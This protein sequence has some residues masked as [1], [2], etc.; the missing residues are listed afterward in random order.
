MITAYFSLISDAISD[1]V[2]GT[3]VGSG[4]D[5]RSSATARSRRDARTEVTCNGPDPVVRGGGVIK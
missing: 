3:G 2:R 1:T 5:N 4:L